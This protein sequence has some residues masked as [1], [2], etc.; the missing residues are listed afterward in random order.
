MVKVAGI[1]P[2]PYRTLEDP[3][4]IEHAVELLEKVAREDVDIA[5]FP[6]LYPYR[7]E[8]QL[9]E[10]TEEL[11]IYVVA[12]LIEEAGGKTYNTAVLISPEG[13]V[14]GRQRKVHTVSS[15]ESFERG[16]SYVPLETSFCKIGVLICI[17]GWG[18]PEGMYTLAKN[19][20]ELIFNPSLIFRKKPQRRMSCL[21]K[22]L[23]YK[24]PIVS[25]NNAV[26]PM[27]I[28]EENPDL[29]AEGGGSII[30][31]PPPFKTM[32]ELESWVKQAA[33]CEDWVT[34]EAGDGEQIITA[35]IDLNALRRLREL[36]EK[37]FGG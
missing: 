26:W 30:V 2:L 23:D 17:D 16:N 18:F 37:F 1:Q 25:P 9:C 32:K 35:T 28:T 14:S 12:G 36:W 33:S 29:P 20:V 6:E 22:A 27:K 13:E 11:G 31:S 5:C 24:I 15:L 21:A 7:G 8:R 19:G 3:R 34:Q 4:N 10:K